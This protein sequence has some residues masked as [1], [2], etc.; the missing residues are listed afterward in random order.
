M[1]FLFLKLE[2]QTGQVCIVG[3]SQSD[4]FKPL[5]NLGFSE[6]QLKF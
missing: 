1:E 4:A 5:P 6:T 3:K 2:Q